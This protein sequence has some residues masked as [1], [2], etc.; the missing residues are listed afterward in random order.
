[1]NKI[2][3]DLPELYRLYMGKNALNKFR[4]DN[5][6]KEGTY[7][8]VLRGKEDNVHLIEILKELDN[9]DNVFEDVYIKLGNRYA[10]WY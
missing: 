5:G 2:G 4:N 8:K 9:Y 10:V 7:K 3:M 6:Y 1:M